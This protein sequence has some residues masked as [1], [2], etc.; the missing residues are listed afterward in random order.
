MSTTGRAT[1]LV[2]DDDEA[3]RILVARRLQHAGYEPVLAATGQQA[4]ETIVA[5]DVD[6]VLMDVMMPEMD[7]L[8]ALARVR[9]FRNAE[10]LPIIMLTAKGD[11]SDVINAMRAGA[12]DYALKPIDFALLLQ[13]IGVQLE[14]RDSRRKNVGP[15]R[16]E[17]RIGA[18]GM[19]IV[20]KAVDT[21]N[22]KVVALKVLPRAMTVDEHFIMRFQR[23]AEYVRGVTHPNVVQL[24]DAG[25]DGDTYYIAMEFVDGADLGFLVAQKT[26]DVLTALQITK[27][28]AAGLATLEAR[29]IVHR[30]I[31]PDNILIDKSGVAKITDL[32]VARDLETGTRL[33]QTGVGVGSAAYASPEQI[34][35]SGDLRADIYSTGCTLFFM[36]TGHDPFPTDKAVDQVLLLKHSGAPSTRTYRADIPKGVEKLLRRMMD[37][38]PEKRFATYE[39]LVHEIER[40]ISHGSTESVVP[41]SF[42]WAGVAAM[43]FV[44]LFFVWWVWH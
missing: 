37:P 22:D 26:Y 20:F 38:K 10:E 15:Y 34:Y 2:V 23:E 39:E 9:Q 31:K 12:N 21:R 6:V 16:I 29:N 28:I 32:G 4:I 5:R 18:G 25:K 19:G 36:L 41:K 43:I 1:I 30:D 14:A 11:G 13:R 42:F 44:V 35:G 8:D 3:N 7:G 17:D 24:V 40:L 33:T 27:Q